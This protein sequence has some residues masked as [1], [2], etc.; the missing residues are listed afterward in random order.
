MVYVE[1]IAII[2]FKQKVSLTRRG[3]SLIDAKQIFKDKKKL[4]IIRWLRND[5]V[6]LRPHKRNSAVATSKNDSIHFWFNAFF[7]WVAHQNFIES[8]NTKLLFIKSCSFIAARLWSTECCNDRCF[9][10]TIP[11]K[12]NN[13][14]V[15]KV[16]TL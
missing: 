13:D 9:L 1:I 12:Y 8:F 2:W 3:F 4:N 7:I 15:R 5:T 10:W 14:T 16:H 11:R 6:V